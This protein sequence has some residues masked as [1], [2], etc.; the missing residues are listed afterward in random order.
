MVVVPPTQPA[1]RGKR[2]FNVQR[3]RHEV[4]RATRAA[5]SGTFLVVAVIA[6]AARATATL[7]ATGQ[8]G[9]PIGRAAGRYTAAQLPE[10]IGASKRMAAPP[11]AWRHATMGRAAR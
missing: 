11:S 8:L 1:G 5:T 7:E 9:I 2:A 10:A 4:D 3:R 6:A